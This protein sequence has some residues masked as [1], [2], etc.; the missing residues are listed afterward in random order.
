[1]LHILEWYETFIEPTNSSTLEI[2]IYIFV[3]VELTF[4]MYNWRCVDILYRISLLTQYFWWCMLFYYVKYYI[5]TQHMVWRRKGGPYDLKWIF[6]TRENVYTSQRGDFYNP[7]T[8]KTGTMENEP[9]VKIS[10]VWLKTP[11]VLLA[12]NLVFTLRENGKEREK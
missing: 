11:L 3:Y 5:G 1:M 8:R 2:Y 10:R 9:K 7:D 12:W 4:L 6:C